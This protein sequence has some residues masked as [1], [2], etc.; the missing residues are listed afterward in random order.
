M[1]SA[2]RG[3][4]RA[5]IAAAAA[6]LIAAGAIIAY[7]SASGNGPSAPKAGAIDS[8]QPSLP[9]TFAGTQLTALPILSA[10]QAAGQ[11]SMPWVLTAL[12]SSRQSLQILYVAGNS[13]CTSPLGAYVLETA[14]TVTIAAISHTDASQH[15]CAADL[16]IGRGAITL[17]SPLGARQL[18]HA[19][20][21]PA[22]RSF[23]NGL[24][25]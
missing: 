4:R 8:L 22:W 23:A 1:I 14:T 20:V 7:I 19:V 13:G 3:H 11:T 9:K 18:V 6:V 5:A 10:G 12:D 15:S 21:D 17:G 2:L 25:G 16:R 24:S